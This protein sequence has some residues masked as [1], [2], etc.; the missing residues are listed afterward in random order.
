MSTISYF[1]T[2]VA[3]FCL[4]SLSSCFESKSASPAFKQ[5]QFSYHGTTPRNLGL[6]FKLRGNT[7][8]VITAVVT[9]PEY[10]DFKN[11]KIQYRWQLDEGV[12]LVDGQRVGEFALVTSDKKIEIHLK[13]GNFGIEG[14]KFVRFEASSLV[15]K[16]RFFIDGIV[17]SQNESSFE[18]F[19]QDIENYKKKEHLNDSK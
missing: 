14:K 1:K 5:S 15:G 10:L 17:S 6:Q 12:E 4:V 7:D 18:N 11:Q 16:N 19:V 8:R 13:V 9:L 2:L 3:I